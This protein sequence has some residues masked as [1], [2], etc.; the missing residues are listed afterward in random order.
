MDDIYSDI[1]KKMP[2]FSSVPDYDILSPV[3]TATEEELKSGLAIPV[4]ITMSGTLE[5]VMPANM[6]GFNYALAFFF[7]KDDVDKLNRQTEEFINGHVIETSEII[8]RGAIARREGRVELRWCEDMYYDGIPEDKTLTILSFDE[9]TPETAA[10]VRTATADW[11]EFIRQEAAKAA[12]EFFVGMMTAL[13]EEHGGE[14]SD[15]SVPDLSD[16][17]PDEINDETDMPELEESINAAFV[18]SKVFPKNKMY[19]RDGQHVSG[20]SL[21]TDEMSNDIS[22]PD[23]GRF[24]VRYTIDAFSMTAQRADITLDVKPLIMEGERK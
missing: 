6:I 3:E 7:G 8:C 24:H 14:E 22:F 10:L 13:A 11:Q 12:Y 5:N 17:I 21:I 1:I 15:I 4:S 20:F 2:M 16:G 18:F 23:G 19:F 9:K